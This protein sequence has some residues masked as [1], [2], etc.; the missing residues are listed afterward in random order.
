MIGLTDAAPAAA[1]ATGG[2]GLLSGIGTA[3]SKL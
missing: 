2:G 3:L 1:A